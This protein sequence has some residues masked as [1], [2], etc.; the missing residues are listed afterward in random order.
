MFKMWRHANQIGVTNTFK[1]NKPIRRISVYFI[2][3]RSFAC[4][5]TLLQA[6]AC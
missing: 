6:I 4:F 3:G 2:D 1:I 5:A